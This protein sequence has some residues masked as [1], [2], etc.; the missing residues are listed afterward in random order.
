[1]LDL[2]P[3]KLAKIGLLRLSSLSL[4]GRFPVYRKAFQN[5][6]ALRLK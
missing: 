5:P 1:M 4:F 6:K 2:F 3:E